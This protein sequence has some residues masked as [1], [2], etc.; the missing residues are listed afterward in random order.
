M[1]HD[2]SVT[3]VYH[4]KQFHCMEL[5]SYFSKI[6]L[7][8]PS[9]VLNLHHILN[10][11]TRHLYKIILSRKFVHQQ[12][13][14]LIGLGSHLTFMFLVDYIVLKASSC[15]LRSPWACDLKPVLRIIILLTFY[16][17]YVAT[18]YESM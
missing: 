15:C 9:D 7:F 14:F 1:K 5:R 12:R 2:F 11:I 6:Y 16:Y 17:I 10:E 8:S 18:L 4:G 13:S 3:K